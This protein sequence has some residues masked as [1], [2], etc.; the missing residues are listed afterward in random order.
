MEIHQLDAMNNLL[1]L[2]HK[3]GLIIGI[4][5]ASSI[6]YGCATACQSAGATLAITYMN[7]K[8]KPHVMP[9]AQALKAPIILPLDVQD[10]EQM[11]AVFDTIAAQFGQLDFLLHSIAFAPK[12][13]LHG[14]VVDCSL[15]GF[16]TATDISCHSFI[17]MAKLAEPLMTQGGS[18]L[19]VSYY[20]AQKVVHHYNMMGP[21]KAMLESAVRYMAAELGPKRI[22][23]NAIS[24]G[25][26]ATRAASGIDHF[27][28]L[29][30]QSTAK[31][32]LHR[33]IDLQDVGHMAAFLVSD[34]AKNITGGIHYIDAG[35][36]VMD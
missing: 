2:Q 28:E 29:M 26:I 19:T 4:A 35:Y 33:Q 6:A 18:L 22:R 24:P 8:A 34:L 31:A 13:D 27:D 36:E 30:A 12:E 14:R 21:V 1:N 16:L 5:N 23:V 15:D 11:H 25:A 20:G 9:L 17:R 10:D 3:K 32:P 7:D